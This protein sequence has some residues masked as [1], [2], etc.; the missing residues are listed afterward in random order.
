MDARA[1]L[2]VAL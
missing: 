2:C 1:A